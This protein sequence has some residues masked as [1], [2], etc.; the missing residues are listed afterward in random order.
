MEIV[1]DRTMDSDSRIKVLQVIA[2]MNVGGPAILV[3][4]LMR[5]LRPDM[6]ETMLVTG[7]CDKDESDYLEE[8]ANDIKATRIPG[9][10]RS[11][12]IT[13]DL[14]AFF[15]LIRE[16]RNFKPDVI[17]THTAKA[18][19][20]GR[21]AGFIARPSG[22]RIHTYH[23]HL[24]HGYFNPRKVKLII[25][26]EKFLELITFKF[27]SIGTVVRNDLVAAGVGETSK[28]EVIFPGM[29]DLDL[30]PQSDARRNLG[31]DPSKVYIVFVGRLTS[32]KRPD[33][34]IELSRKLKV[35]Y[36]LAHM[37][38]T[39][40]GDLLDAMKEIATKESLPILFL[41]W[42]NDIDMILSASDIA[43]LCSDNEGIPLTL[44]QASQAGLPIVSTNVGSVCDIVEDGVTGILTDSTSEALIKGVIRILDDTNLG[45]KLGQS[46]QERARIY[47]STEEMIRRHEGLYS[48]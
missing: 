28:Y 32:I 46:G 36:P 5:N 8:V 15:I 42:R 37:I 9:L 11:I 34:L 27:V 45:V 4:E 38:I 6:F 48:Q 47:F 10:G 3:A 20:L 29:K 1:K 41:G 22:K 30:F 23:G 21:L 39:G 33:R 43:I 26:L 40:A 2:R 19:V 16:I 7:Y 24:L 13:A 17:H 35:E 44:I 18:G 12:S 31:L 25:L 14:R